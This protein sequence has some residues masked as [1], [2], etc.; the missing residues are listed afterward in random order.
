MAPTSKTWRP[1]WSRSATPPGRTCRVALK[2][3]PRWHCDAPEP[4]ARVAVVCALG[5]CL[6]GGLLDDRMR[7]RRRARRRPGRRR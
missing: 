7:E 4:L 3:S 1:G 5:G 2:E 6:E